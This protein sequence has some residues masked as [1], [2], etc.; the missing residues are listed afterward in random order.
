MNTRLTGRARRGDHWI[1]FTRR[2]LSAADKAIRP[3]TPGVRR[4]AFRS[5]TCRTLSSVFDRLPSISFCKLRIR[6]WSPAR[7]AAKIRCRSRRTRSSAARQST[8]SHSRASS[9]GPFAPAPPA[10][11]T[12]ASNLSL[13]SNVSSTV[14]FADPPDPRQPSFEAGH[15]DPYPAGSSARPLGGAIIACRF[16]AALRRAGIR[17]LDHPVLDHPVPATEFSVPHGRPTSLG[18]TAT[19]FPR[20]ARMRPD[21]GGRLLDP[22][23]MV[24]SQREGNV[25]A[26]IRRFPAASPTPPPQQPS[27]G[28]RQSRGINEGS[29]DSPVR[30]SSRPWPP[31]M[32]GG[33]SAS[34]WAPHPAVTSDAC[35]GEDRPPDTGPRSRPRHRPHLQPT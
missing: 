29:P 14:L 20:C 4:P 32:R 28:A 21:R 3:S 26:G 25:P 34:P 12:P 13:G 30:S 6:L 8:A 10:G 35:Q 15:Q 9:L 18:W 17:F 22:G 31:V 5:V 2:S 11:E 16:P 23:A 27:A 7:V 1:S 24:S 19:G 33:P